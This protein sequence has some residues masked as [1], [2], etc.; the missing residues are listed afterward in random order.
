MEV[1]ECRWGDGANEA[2]LQDIL[3]KDKDK[4]IKA[5]A[6]VH[7]ETTTGVTSDIAKVPG[8]L[9]SAL[10]RLRRS[11][12]STAELLCL[13]Q[14]TYVTTCGM[15]SAMSGHMHTGTLAEHLD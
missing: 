4:K 7:N 2:K 10:A 13:D 8:L 1:I 11:S 9:A 6:V 5:V 12:S 3:S 15:C 14:Q